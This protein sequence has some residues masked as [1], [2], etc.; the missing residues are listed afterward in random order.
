MKEYGILDE[1]HHVI[2]CDFKTWRRWIGDG[3]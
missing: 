2:T 3:D 1:N